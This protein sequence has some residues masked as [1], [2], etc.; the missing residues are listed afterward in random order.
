[1]IEYWRDVSLGAIDITGSRVFGWVEIEIMRD[2][3]G[4]TPKPPVQGQDGW[5]CGTSPSTQ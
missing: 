4:G 5:G 1:M 3:A 2:K